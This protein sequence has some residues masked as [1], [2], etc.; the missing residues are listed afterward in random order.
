[1]NRIIPGLI[2]LIL[3]ILSWLPG[4]ILW[5]LAGLLKFVIL[6]IFQYR[7]EVVKA[8]LDRSIPEY[9]HLEQNLIIKRFYRHFSELFLE[10]ALFT[11]L[12]PDRNS[13]RIRFSNPEPI[14]GA[15]EKKQNIIIIS[16]HYG[17]WEWNL[18]PILAAGY[19]VFAVYKPQS[20]KLADQLMKNIRMKPGIM[21]VPMKD[22]MRVITREIQ[23]NKSPFALLLVAD[24]TP[25]RS[26]IRFWTTF[27]N[28]E[29]AFFTGGEKLSRRFHMPLFYV[30]QT[31]LG[32]A[33]YEVNVTL[34][35]DGFS[36]AEDGMITR[37]FAELLE[38]SILRVPYLWLWSHRRW[39]YHKEDLPLH[40]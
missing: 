22:T 6:N 31:K 1:M 10:M 37:R 15:F 36:P 32:F 4:F 8:N 26:E 21:L 19:R 28:Q 17:N 16:G 13:S 25:A 5:S 33:K 3:R 11:G 29:T 30:D 34:L 20:S 18:L 27:L 14:A 24:Q 35:Y 2:W 40:V 12:K 7:R 38:D 23:E 9:P 39:K